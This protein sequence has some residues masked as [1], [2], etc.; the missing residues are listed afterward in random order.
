MRFISLFIPRS[1]FWSANRLPSLVNQNFIF[2]K[3]TFFSFLLES[4]QGSRI[5]KDCCYIPLILTTGVTK[6]FKHF[7]W[8]GCSLRQG[9]ECASLKQST[10]IIGSIGL[11]L[12][13]PWPKHHNHQAPQCQTHFSVC[14]RGHKTF[15]FNDSL[16]HD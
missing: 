6:I 14:R 15:S 11:Q 7:L 13:T 2:K 1:Y 3:I 5:R 8:S 9:S 4:R 12:W 16:H 10:I